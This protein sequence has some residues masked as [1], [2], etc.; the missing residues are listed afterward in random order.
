METDERIELVFG[1]EAI[2]DLSS[3]FWKGIQVSPKMYVT[4]ELCPEL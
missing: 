2:L 3:L 4:L 1:I